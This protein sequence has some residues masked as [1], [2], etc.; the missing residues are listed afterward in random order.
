MK[1]KNIPII[2]I[3]ACLFYTSCKKSNTEVVN[4][5]SFT[6]SQEAILNSSNQFGFNLFK[7]LSASGPNDEN[8][9]ISPLSISFALTMT[10]NGAASQTATDMQTT[11]GYGDMSKA[12]INQ[13]CKE[14][15]QTI[16]T[17]DPK[18]AMEIANSIW[19]RNTFAV[20]DS[21]LTLNKT[22]FDAEV[23]PAD[24][25]NPQT[26]GLINN[27]VNLK[28]HEK[29][30]SV[31]TEIP[32]D[33][34]MYLIN[35]IY[36][37]GN[38]KYKFETKNTEKASFTL[39]D[40]STYQT[41][42]M[43]MKEKF[44]YVKNNLISA[45]ELPYGNGGFSMI[46]LLPNDGK[47]YADVISNLTMDNW[48]QW[49]SQMDS[50]NV[51][52]KLPKFKFKYEKTLNQNLTDLGMGV[53]FDSNSA[54]FSGISEAAQLFI[55]FVLHKSF[56]DVNEEGTEAA[57][58]TVVGIITTSIDPSQPT[59]QYFDVN[60]PFVFAIKENTTNSILFMGLVK[61]PVV[62]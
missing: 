33:A 41:D 46:V 8:L 58:V 11:L 2:L 27:W 22:F 18:V 57:A 26:V 20:K 48:T 4:K 37:K 23:K 52:V 24:F 16:L 40:G 5:V 14:L 54:N 1:T 28:T 29:I 62:E 50:A 17:I 13:S 7:D 19:Y 36:F 30:S 61:K 39:A 53:A 25:S 49:N 38:W 9:F 42:F 55:S 6:K 59:Y 44:K 35:A 3:I 60:K 15:M 10:Y 31:I 47:T 56:V 51:F 34:I 45:I 32:S 43:N 21:F 12:T